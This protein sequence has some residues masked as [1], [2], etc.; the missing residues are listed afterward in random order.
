MTYASTSMRLRRL[1]NKQPVCRR[2]SRCT[3]VGWV[4][5]ASGFTECSRCGTG[6]GAAGWGRR[7]S[8]PPV[9]PSFGRGWRITTW[10]AKRSLRR[11]KARPLSRERVTPTSK[12]Q[13]QPGSCIRR[14]WRGCRRL[15]LFLVQ[16]D[17]YSK[18]YHLWASS[19]H[20][21]VEASCGQR[22]SSGSCVSQGTSTGCAECT[23]NLVHFDFHRSF[24]VRDRT[25]MGLSTTAPRLCE[26]A[27]Q[28][29]AG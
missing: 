19:C 1:Q 7:T 24:R 9:G 23:W 26:D 14:K 27:K 4:I 17:R 6:A 21:A 15:S 3:P 29:V 5:P 22:L 8:I 10:V 18:S 20:R 13:Q 25:A 11:P 28:A 12:M 16:E 2:T